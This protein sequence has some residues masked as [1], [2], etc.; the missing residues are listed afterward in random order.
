[1]VDN[2]LLDIGDKE[3]LALSPEFRTVVKSLLNLR[4][5]AYDVLGSYP[6]KNV[7]PYFYQCSNTIAKGNQIATALGTVQ[8]SIKIAADSAFIA[9]SI[10]GSST[11]DFTAFMRQDASDRILM[12]EAVVSNALLGTA[13]RP[14]FLHKP[15]ALPPNT[16]IS[17]DFTDISNV[18]NNEIYFALCGFKIYSRTLS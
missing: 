6:Q 18:A 12:N 1:M 2:T 16:T 11:N 4:Q 15:L 5:A 7:V 3:L 8:N 14:G 13:E 9:V 10:R 17:F